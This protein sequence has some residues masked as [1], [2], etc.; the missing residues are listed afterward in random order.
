MSALLQRNF[1]GNK[2]QPYCNERSRCDNVLQQIGSMRQPIATD[3]VDVVANGATDEN[4]GGIKFY[5][6]ATEW[7]FPISPVKYERGSM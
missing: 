4:I 7:S 2:F 3:H 6:I 5:P 1:C